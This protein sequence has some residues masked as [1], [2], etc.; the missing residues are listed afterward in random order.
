MR[1]AVLLPLVLVAA[2]CGEAERHTYMVPLEGQSREELRPPEPPKPEQ[3]PPPLNSAVRDSPSWLRSNAPLEWTVPEGWTADLSTRPNRLIEITVEKNGPGNAP[4]KFIVLNGV[5]EH[6]GAKQAS[7]QRAEQFYREDRAP[8]TTERE[9]N[10]VKETR[11]VIHGRFEGQTELGTGEQLAEDNWT[12]VFGWVE[13]PDGS[14]MYKF[15][16]PDAVINA[17]QSKVDALLG[18]MKPREKKPQ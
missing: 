1:S 12:L 14:I 9:H 15:Q 8:V 3:P 18:S 5:D 16:G 6:P 7:L 4:I 11:Y 17:N 13:G 10:G 2:A